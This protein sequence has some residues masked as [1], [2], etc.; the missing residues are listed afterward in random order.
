MNQTEGVAEKGVRDVSGTCQGPFRNFFTI[1]QG[2][3]RFALQRLPRWSSFG[4]I[5]GTW[6]L[7]FSLGGA[8]RGYASRHASQGAN[9]R[10]R[11]QSGITVARDNGRLALEWTCGR[12]RVLEGGLLVRLHP[13]G[14]LDLQSISSIARSTSRRASV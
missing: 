7:P 13:C 8:D 14:G 6:R 4:E 10:H 9:E 1:S 11:H 5:K 2:L 3:I 12:R